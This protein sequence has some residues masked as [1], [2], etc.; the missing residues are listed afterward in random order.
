MEELL[1]KDKSV[2]KLKLWK[3]KNKRMNIINSL[4]VS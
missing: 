4:L 3:N 2:K 1:T